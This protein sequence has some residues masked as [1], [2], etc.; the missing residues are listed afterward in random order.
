[1]KHIRKFK[2]III[3]LVFTTTLIIPVFIFIFRQP[4]YVYDSGNYRIIDNGRASAEDQKAFQ[5]KSGAGL[6]EQK[7]FSA[8]NNLSRIFLDAKIEKPVIAVFNL[9]ADG[10]LPVRNNSFLFE[11]RKEIY[12]EFQ[13]IQDSK[14]KI[15]TLE[16]K[17]PKNYQNR[18][19]F[20]FYAAGDGENRGALSVNGEVSMDKALKVELVSEI[21]DP[22]EK[23][24][25]F[26][27][28]ITLNKPAFVRFIIYP[29]YIFFFLLFIM[30]LWRALAVI[31]DKKF[32]V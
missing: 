25:L 30:A 29:A 1:M 17:I 24:D 3:F 19:L 12:W 10:K 11:K 27:K 20:P 5:Q 13:P 2:A 9:Y 32:D 6:L 26:N 31:L 23:I 7:I 18:I 21:G 8:E 22:L 16:I 4:F 14:N 28:K 15:Y